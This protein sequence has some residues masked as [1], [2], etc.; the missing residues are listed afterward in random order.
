MLTGK[1]IIL[2]E[3]MPESIEQLRIW[4]ND[5]SARQYF[6]EWKDITPDKQ[7]KWYDERGN[8]SNQNHVYFQIMKIDPLD[9]NKK[10]L[11]GCCGALNIDWRIRSAELSIFIDKNHQGCGFGR[12]TLNILIDY[13]FSEINLHRFWGECYNS[14]NAIKLYTSVGFK[15][16]GKIR[17]SWFHNGKYGDSYIFSMLD[18][19]WR[20]LQGK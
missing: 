5:P 10:I 9:S 19:E 12:E 2:E 11:I 14:N 13:V 1:N 20:V 4:R 6:R 17:H 8:N 3:V 16:D 18:D 15:I 7:K